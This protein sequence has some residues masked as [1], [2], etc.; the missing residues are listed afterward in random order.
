MLEQSP[1]LTEFYRAYRD[2]LDN[3]APEQ[4]P[5]FCRGDG[6]CLNC[7]IWMD[8]T[9]NNAS[10][11]DTEMVAQFRAA[12]LNGWLPFNTGENTISYMY[13]TRNY[14]CHLNPKR[15]RWVRERAQ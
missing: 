13:E 14:L 1:T 8:Q 3:G 6:L 10:C 11:I 12:K 5:I 15:I 7:S 2:W 9:G 4:H